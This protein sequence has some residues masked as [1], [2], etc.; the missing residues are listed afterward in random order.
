MSQPADYR[1]VIAA[2]MERG[3]EW[4]IDP[5]LDRIRDLMDLLGEPQRA[6]PVIHVSGTNGKTSTARLID[7][8]LRERGLRVGLYTSP[9]LTTLRERI[10]IDGE[11]ISETHFAGTYAD[12]APYLSLIHI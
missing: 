2:I 6:Y 1:A 4:E 9:Q 11:P 7:A 3:V 12:L 10:E 8:L 5:S